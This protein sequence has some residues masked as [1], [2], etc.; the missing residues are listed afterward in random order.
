[1]LHKKDA[2]IQCIGMWVL[3]CVALLL[4]SLLQIPLGAVYAAAGIGSGAFL[5]WLGGAHVVR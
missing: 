4:D 5:I 1:M 2:A 3:L